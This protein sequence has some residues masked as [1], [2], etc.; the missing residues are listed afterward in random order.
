MNKYPFSSVAELKDLLSGY[1]ET[2]SVDIANNLTDSPKKKKNEPEPLTMSGLAYHLGFKSLG[3]F[4]A[5][6]AKGKYSGLLKRARLRVETEYEKK[7]HNQSASGAIFALKSLG[8]CDSKLK[9]RQKK[10]HLAQ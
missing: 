10:G 9:A 5:S 4:E 6:E 7:L 2:N 8:W 1:F 3:D